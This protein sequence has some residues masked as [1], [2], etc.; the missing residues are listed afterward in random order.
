MIPPDDASAIFTCTRQGA[1]AYIAAQAQSS[2]TKPAGGPAVNRKFVDNAGE[3]SSRD[4]KGQKFRIEQAGLYAFR[5]HG[6][7]LAIRCDNGSPRK[8]ER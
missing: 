5:E 3:Y 8:Q 2:R 4:L 1:P 6:L 7:P